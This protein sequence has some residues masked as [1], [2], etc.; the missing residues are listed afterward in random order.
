MSIHCVPSPL[1]T[2]AYGEIRIRPLQTSDLRFRKISGR[3]QISVDGKHLIDGVAFGRPFLRR[4]DRPPIR[5]PPRKRRRITYDDDSD[6]ILDEHPNT[7]HL[8]VHAEPD[9]PNDITADEGSETDD[10]YSPDEEEINDLSA[11]LKDIRNDRYSKTGEDDFA[12]AEDPEEPSNP[13]GPTGSPRR[14]T[15]S[16]KAGGLCLEGEGMLKLVD[17]NGRP[18]P[19]EYNNPLLD[20]Y[21]HAE[22]EHQNQ[23]GLQ[24]KTPK[25]K[26]RRSNGQ[27]DAERAF[28]EFSTQPE[29]VSKSISKRSRKGVRFQD[30]QL[31]TPATMREYQDSHQS[32]EDLQSSRDMTP[33]QYESDKENSQPLYEAAGLSVVSMI[34]GLP[35]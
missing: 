35:N 12:V 32:D 17:E 16:R 24:G 14:L 26:K 1:F 3:H 18:Y 34:S 28:E 29:R 7:R 6:G 10:D 31:E 21:L 4:T 11:E 8:A 25:K 20:L 2:D 15:R 13:G 9:D 22:D 33:N 23:P 27:K 30:G 19:G 5:I